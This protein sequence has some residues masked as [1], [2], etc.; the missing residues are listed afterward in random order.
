MDRRER[1]GDLTVAVLA[2]LQGW[3]SQM[4][5]A[6]PVI[7][8]SFDA[9]KSTCTA[10]PAIQARYT[11]ADG[12]QVDIEMPILLDCPVQFPGGG[13]YSLTFPIAPGDEA[14]CIFS[15]RCIDNWWYLGGV[16]KQ[17]ELRM[18][19]LSDGFIIP[20]IRSRPRFINV[21][22]IATELRSD[23]GE[24]YIQLSQAGVFMQAKNIKIE[25]MDSLELKCNHG[26]VW[27][28]GDITQYQN[29][30]PVSSNS[31]PAP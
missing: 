26:V 22:A 19:D 12:S 6:M 27:T 17:A 2:A 11:E 15:S 1:Q 18:H 10:Q 30:I 31:P 20:Q 5:T 3:Q 23:D 14:L 4:W 29:G 16:Q 8:K 7:I 13:G 21:N 25:A 9:A 24:T 28:P